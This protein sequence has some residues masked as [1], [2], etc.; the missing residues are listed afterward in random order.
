[1]EEK[2]TAT[3]EKIQWAAIEEFA[4]KGWAPPCARL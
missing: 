2:S 4:E 3:L 1:M